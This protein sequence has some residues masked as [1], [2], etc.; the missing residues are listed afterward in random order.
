MNRTS[1][2]LIIVIAV[3]LC[4]TGFL[5]YKSL[6]E[7]NTGGRISDGKSVM[8]TA[9]AK[10][11][12][13]GSYVGRSGPQCEFAACSDEGEPHWAEA[14]ANGECPDM[15][16]YIGEVSTWK[17]GVDSTKEIIF[18]YPE[19]LFTTYIHTAKWP[20]VV[21]LVHTPYSCVVKGTEASPTGKTEKK[22]IAGQEYCITT[23]S[24]DTAGSTTLNYTFTSV[25]G[26]KSLQ[27]IFGLQHSS[28]TSLSSSENVAC[29]E[30]HK[31]FNIGM[32]FR[33]MMATVEYNQ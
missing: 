27:F 32:F 19:K 3:I 7:K 2:P 18:S 8:C 29:E 9:D 21:T 11:C 4:F 13:D 23:Q 12:P 28:C 14:C 20:P 30:E 17:R 24:K 22:V 6:T 31:A 25:F 5:W 10:L 26:E 33:S 16:L 15:A 1:L